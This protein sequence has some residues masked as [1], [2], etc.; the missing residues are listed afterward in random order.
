MSKQRGESLFEV[1]IA[2]A[3]VG[4][5]AAGIVKISSTSVKNAR[6]ANEQTG[7]VA[8]GEKKIA[9]LKARSVNE[10]QTFWADLSL[11][12][13]I[14]GQYCYLVSKVDLSSDPMNY[15]P[16]ESPNYASAGLIKGVVTIF[17]D[18]KGTVLACNT[19]A[20]GKLNY[21]RFI[22]LS[23]LVTK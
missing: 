4:I 22:E 1:I 3:I 5:T 7:A 11:S 17:W 10:Y 9:E 12:S 13:G 6:Y 20:N 15:L 18:A 8:L 21:N 23:T 14:D 19:F 16:T 2:L